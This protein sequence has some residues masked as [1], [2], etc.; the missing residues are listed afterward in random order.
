MLLVVVEI[1]EFPLHFLLDFLESLDLDALELVPCLREDW[2]RSEDALLRPHAGL[3][4]LE[5]C[6]D[7]ELELHPRTP[8]LLAS[9]PSLL[10][11]LGIAFQIGDICLSVYALDV[12]HRHQLRERDEA[13]TL[14]LVAEL[15]RVCVAGKNPEERQPEGSSVDF[16]VG[17][18]F[19]E[20]R[21]KLIPRCTLRPDNVFSV[22]TVGLNGRISLFDFPKS[23]SFLFEANHIRT[24]NFFELLADLHGEMD[25]TDWKLKVYRS[26]LNLWESGSI[27]V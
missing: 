13:F 20:R 3:H 4:L 7:A 9:K 16:I 8:R 18:G 10:D 26:S 19:L 15:E 11:H 17:D 25:T 24:G 6:L 22:D 21:Q 23:C 14:R 5:V 27:S 1:D 12:I 2:T